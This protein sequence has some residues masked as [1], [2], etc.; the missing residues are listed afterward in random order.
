MTRK[1]CV[2]T[3]LNVILIVLPVQNVRLNVNSKKL[4]K[5]ISKL[6]IVDSLTGNFTCKICG[7]PE[8]AGPTHEWT[9][10]NKKERNEFLRKEPELF[11]K[12]WRN[13]WKC[14]KCDKNFAQKR[15]PKIRT[16]KYHSAK[17]KLLETCPECG[18][19]VKFLHDHMRYKHG[20]PRPFKCKQKG[21]KKRAAAAVRCVQQ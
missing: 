12:S 14:D 7:N 3:S 15:G 6:F 8:T 11:P 4:L 13:N 19:T 18:K 10:M 16:E 1:S 17:D 9:H 20:A 21:C 5:V 2:V